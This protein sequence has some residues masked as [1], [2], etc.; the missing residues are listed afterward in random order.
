MPK[1][2]YKTSF[3]RTQSTLLFVVK[4]LIEKVALSIAPIHRSD[5]HTSSLGT[6]IPDRLGDLFE[7]GEGN[8][9]EVHHISS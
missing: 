6:G 1:E 5:R 2:S 7:W 8:K 3:L 9:L 4:R